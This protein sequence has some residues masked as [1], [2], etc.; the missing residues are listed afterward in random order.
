MTL[1][2][3]PATDAEYWVTVDIETGRIMAQGSPALCEDVARN[4]PRWIVRQGDLFD[5]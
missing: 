4:G 2:A 1:R 5:C 3:R